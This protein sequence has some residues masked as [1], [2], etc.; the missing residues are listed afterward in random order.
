M[1]TILSHIVRKRYS[2][3][4]EDIAT[5][6]LTFLLDSSDAVR[7]AFNGILEGRGTRP[8]TRAV[9]GAASGR[10]DASGHVRLRPR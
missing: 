2:R 8:S 6:G 3:A 7:R 9:H 1:S 5:D 10:D 4:N